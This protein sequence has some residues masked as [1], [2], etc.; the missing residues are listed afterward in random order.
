[1]L[2]LK[3]KTYTI[4]Y[5]DCQLDLKHK[6]LLAHMLT[7]GQNTVTSQL[8]PVLSVLRQLIVLS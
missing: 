7:A 6:Q 8:D 2:L 4:F 1:M 5:L 3:S